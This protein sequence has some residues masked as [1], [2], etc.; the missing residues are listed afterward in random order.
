MYFLNENNINFTGIKEEMI[1]AVEKSVNENKISHD[2]VNEFIDKEV[3]FGHNRSY[4][5]VDIVEDTITQLKDLK[6]E[7]LIKIIEGKG[8]EVPSESI[9]LDVVRP[10]ILKLVELH[11]TMNKEINLVFIETIKT[12]GKN[13]VKKE[14]NYYFVRVDLINAVLSIRM[15]P[16]SNVVTGRSDNI[17]KVKNNN[18][19]YKIL[20]VSKSIFSIDTTQP[21][22][23]KS[24]LYKIAKTLTE[25]AEEKW[26]KEVEKHSE[27]IVEFSEKMESKLKEIKPKEFDLEFRLHRL[28][29]RGLIQSNFE[30]LKEREEG[31]IGYVNA[32]HFS[33]R[34]GG[35]VK[36]SSI[37]KENAIELSEIYY[38][39]RDTIDKQEKYDLILVNWF[40]EGQRSSVK[41]KLETNSEFGLIH[42]YQYVR[43]GDIKYV[44]SKVE[45][46]KRQGIDE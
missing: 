10:D 9:M 5:F 6:R 24:T 22:E 42:F 46:F 3:R 12:Q 45:Y 29:E 19:Y 27:E 39:T 8:F 18:L 20:E 11:Y 26:R 16:R 25:R 35:K 34:A 2:A 4:F 30:Q 36:A 28:L 40:V 33:D 15:R 21:R 37:E 7:G 43:E 32:F 38:D 44:L 41:T 13:T 17:K 31:K 1:R 14:N 23:F